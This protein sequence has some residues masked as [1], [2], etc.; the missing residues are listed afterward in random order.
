MIAI[1]LTG[2][3]ILGISCLLGCQLTPEQDMEPV[4]SDSR[5]QTRPEMIDKSFHKGEGNVQPVSAQGMTHEETELKLA[6]LWSRVDEMETRLIRQEEKLRLLERGLMLGIVPEALMDD[7]RL[8]Q[9][10][11][12]GDLFQEPTSPPVEK[13]KNPE[14]KSP[15]EVA[16]DERTFRQLLGEA[17]AKFNAGR[18]GQAI[19][20]YQTIHDRFPQQ[21]VQGQHLYWIG[22]SWF[23]LKEDNLAAENLEQLIQNFHGSP[24]LAHANFYLAKVD[25]RR[26]FRQKALQRLR[27]VVEQFGDKDVAEMARHELSQLQESL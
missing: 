8:I 17:Q 6:K 2:A 14:E 12:S 15:A 21:T 22:L 10:K 24:W 25:L 1:R 9:E 7:D 27:N 3:W 18:Y 20:D 13:L 4:V 11:D 23:Y 26:G 19:A 16:V 5:D